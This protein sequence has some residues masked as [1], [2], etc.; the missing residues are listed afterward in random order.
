MHSQKY[1]ESLLDGYQKNCYFIHSFVIESS[2][3]T[4]TLYPVYM[5]DNNLLSCYL[6]SLRTGG[7]N[8]ADEWEWETSLILIIMIWGKYKRRRPLLGRSRYLEVSGTQPSWHLR[9]RE[10]ETECEFTH[11][12]KVVT[13]LQIDEN[14]RS[15]CVYYHVA[16][17]VVG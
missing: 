10:R 13:M 7:K 8:T 14:E 3:F 11:S 9:L 2:G 4:P 16:Q 12:F 5:D 15:H 6:F 1:L 17:N